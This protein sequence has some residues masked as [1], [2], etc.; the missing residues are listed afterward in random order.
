MEPATCDPNCEVSFTLQN[1]RAYACTK[2]GAIRR[3]TD[4]RR[5]PCAKKPAA[6][7]LQK[8]TEATM[9]KATAQRRLADRVRT[10]AAWRTSDKGRKYFADYAR[11]QRRNKKE[12][13]A[14]AVKSE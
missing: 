9:G 3:L 2:C 1:R 12:T 8:W 14:K 7:K 6:I 13:E 11:K 5:Q 10:Q 4:F